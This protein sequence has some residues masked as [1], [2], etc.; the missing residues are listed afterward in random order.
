MISLG[1]GKPVSLKRHSDE[2]TSIAELFNDGD[3]EV[4][5][6]L[7]DVNGEGE[8]ASPPVQQSS[9][10]SRSPKRSLFCSY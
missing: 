1:S 3:D 4:A 5:E 2:N 8:H 7:K 6:R 9:D 10:A